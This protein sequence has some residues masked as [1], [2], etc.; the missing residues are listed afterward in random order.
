M[1]NPQTDQQLLDSV[2][3]PAPVPIKLFSP[4]RSL[5]EVKAIQ[6]ELFIRMEVIERQQQDV[7]IRMAAHDA[8]VEER[9]N[10]L[11]TRVKESRV[12]VDSCVQQVKSF[13]SRGNLI[14]LGTGVGTAVVVN[15]IRY[16][17]K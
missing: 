9:M 16:F 7:I 2:M 13:C 8:V 14:M 3:G 6:S 11:L 17:L 10:G 1:I 4:D 15:V 12:I 5:D